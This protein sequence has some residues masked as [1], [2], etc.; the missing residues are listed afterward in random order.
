MK[1]KKRP[2]ILFICTDQQRAD[3]VGCW[4]SD[5]VRTPNLNAL[6]ARGMKFSH[7]FTNSPL[8]GPARSALASG[9]RPH[10]L[11][12]LNNDGYLPVNTPNL[13]QRLRDSGYW[14]GLIGKLD[15]EKG[16]H[17][18]AHPGR[19]SRMPIMSAYGFCDHLHASS[20]ME[21]IE[22]PIQP[23]H[24]DLQDK[25]LYEAFRDDRAKRNEDR[26]DYDSPL[27][28]EDH[29][30]GYIGQLACRWI[31]EAPERYPWFLQVSFDGPH[32]PIDPPTEYADNYRDADMPPA[33]A[34]DLN[35]KSPWAQSRFVTADEEHILTSQRQYAAECEHIDDQIGRIVATLERKGI[36][37]ETLIVFSSD[38][39][40]MLGDFGLYEKYVPYESS[41]RIPLVI[42]GPG[43][44]AGGSSSELVELIDLNSTMADAAGLPPQPYVDTKSLWP[45]LK[46]DSQAH[47]ECAV[48]A[49]DQYRCLRTAD[50]KYVENIGSGSELY[51][52]KS[53]PQE[54]NNLMA[55]P[56]D[57]T[58]EETA[59]DLAVKLSEELR[60]DSWMGGSV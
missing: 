44:S 42:A 41:V 46:G 16:G 51:D 14:T 47:R 20:E 4:G 30:E 43:V 3:Y 2:N 11:G 54:Q 36:L 5:H 34:P 52:L 57:K 26:V 19:D 48:I 29:I 18:Q 35:G 56:I 58:A 39:G 37:D 49:L 31:D 60:A 40:E 10:K 13:Y 9:I 17:D 12:I 22:N 24:Y 15:L 27:S 59:V 28:G 55:D 32:D 8:C 25:G 33:I 50:Y 38:H 1:E 53:D 7:C 21:A 45:V 23:F 6:A